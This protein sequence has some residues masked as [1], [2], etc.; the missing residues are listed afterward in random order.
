M[1]GLFDGVATALSEVFG[2]AVTYTPAG[3]SARS[4][5]SVLRRTPV[6]AIGPDGVDVLV[7]APTWRV[8][9]DL[10]PEVARD[11]RVEDS[12]GAFRVVNVW[13]QGSPAVDAHLVC[14]LEALEE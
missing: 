10:V 5:Q 7:V 13:P 9:R 1:A 12:D 3:G 4:V 6:T 14:E 11:D 8:R 2:A